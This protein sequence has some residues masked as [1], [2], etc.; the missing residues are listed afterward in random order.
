MRRRFSTTPWC[1][2]LV[3]LSACDAT[4][5]VEPTPIPAA[6][7]TPTFELL[8]E[9]STVALREQL[10]LYI[11]VRNAS[12]FP[13][14]AP[15]ITYSTTSP[16]VAS[17]SAGGLVTAVAPGTATLAAATVFA[18]IALR[19]SVTITVITPT[20]H[21]DLVLRAEAA[22]WLP[23]PAHLEA[24]GTVEWRGGTIAGAGVPVDVV[25]LVDST[26]SIVD[27]I[28]LRGGSASRTFQGRGTVRYCSNACWDLSEHGVIYVH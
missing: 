2:C 15:V 27:S 9:R 26:D 1:I 7:P 22:G 5:P 3:A 14:G 18:G 23:T 28:D 24:G 4:K 19:D 10:Q 16:S 11:L 17:V 8:P 13:V 25:Y 6:T 21:R 20:I 12:G